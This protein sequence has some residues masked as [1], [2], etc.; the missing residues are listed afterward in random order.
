MYCLVSF[1]VERGK[2]EPSIAMLK[3]IADVLNVNTVDFFMEGR[4]FDYFKK[5]GCGDLLLDKNLE[6]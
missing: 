3:K 6:W 5:M 1:A 4:V 2:T